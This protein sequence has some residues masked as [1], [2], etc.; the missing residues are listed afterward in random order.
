[1]YNTFYIDDVIVNAHFAL[2]II[3]MK[4]ILHLQK[5]FKTNQKT[6]ET[7]PQLASVTPIG[8]TAWY[9]HFN[10]VA[11]ESSFMDTN[12]VLMHITTTI[13][14][15]HTI[16]I[17]D[18]CTQYTTL[19]IYIYIYIYSSENYFWKIGGFI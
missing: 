11:G 14:D 8:M 12:Q 19:Y 17:G 6:I 9:R 7:D 10:E 1:V 2:K 5:S 16:S 15:T 13:S 4:K 18:M 3:K